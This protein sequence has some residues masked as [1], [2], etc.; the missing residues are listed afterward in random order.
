M[1]LAY[2]CFTCSTLHNDVVQSSLRFH[3]EHAHEFVHGFMETWPLYHIDCAHEF[4][5]VVMKD[6]GHM[7]KRSQM[8][9]NAVVDK[10]TSFVQTYVNSI[11]MIGFLVITRKK[12][13][14]RYFS[15][16][17]RA[18]IKGRSVRKSIII[19]TM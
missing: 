9:V 15:T 10:C 12:R 1:K 2:H 8:C 7:R 13:F 17:Q 3:I 6:S 4:I 19:K 16:T 14:D 11:V 18:R 5:H